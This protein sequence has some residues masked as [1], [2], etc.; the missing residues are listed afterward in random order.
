LT[1]SFLSLCIFLLCS[2]SFAE[3]A[4][5]NFDYDHLKYNGTVKEECEMLLRKPLRGGHVE[6]KTPEIDSAFLALISGE[7]T[8]NKQKLRDYLDENRIDQGDIGGN[9][10]RGLSTI[11]NLAN[12]KRETARYF[13]IHD[14]SYSEQSLAFPNNIDSLSYRA[15]QFSYWTKVQQTKKVTLAHVF[16]NRL[17]ESKTY[18]DLSEPCLTTKFE[19]QKFNKHFS[20]EGLFL[21]VELVQP[22]LRPNIKTEYYSIAPAEG[23]TANQYK[24]LAIIYIAASVRKGSWLIPAFH[25]CIDELLSPDSHDDP[26]NI[27]LKKFTDAVLETLS[28]L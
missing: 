24:R 7:L 6:A 20:L 3:P 16:V 19:K 18:A 2:W 15:N 26:Q 9:I 17:G 28:K 11:L 5:Q 4:S 27:D 22:R 13:I 8:V 1:N 23:F 25:V 21:G 10:D 14:V 12:N